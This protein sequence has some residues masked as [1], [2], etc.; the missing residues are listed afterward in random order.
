MEKHSIKKTNKYTLLKWNNLW[1]AGVVIAAYLGVYLLVSQNLLLRQYRSVLVLMAV[2]II[3]AVSLNLVTGFLGELSL[4]HAGFMMV[5]AY[6]GAIFSQGFAAAN[7]NMPTFVVIILAIIIGGLAASVAGMIIGIP[8]LRLSGDYLAIVTLAFGEILRSL[9]EN[10]KIT[11]GAAGLSGIETYTNYKNFTY[12]FVIMII[13]IIV[14]GN[15]INSRHGRAICSIRENRIAAES[16]GINLSKFKLMAFVLGSFFAGVAGVIHAHN[17]GSIFPSEAGYNKS[18]DILVMVVLGG[19]GNIRG[20]IIAAIVLTLL[21]EILRDAADYRQLL[22]AVVL[23]A[24]ML[25]N[26][27]DKFTDFRNRIFGKLPHLSKL[28]KK[29]E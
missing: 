16:I 1:K 24:M 22:Y 25:M 26:S 29:G 9:F 20:S 18:I 5:G 19:M 13:T 28:Q 21:P 2:N 8:V 3:L 15:L 17:Q 4:G 10:M 11:N 23:I 27:S 7:P 12:A 6:A 14:I